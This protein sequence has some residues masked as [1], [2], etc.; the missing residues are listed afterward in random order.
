MNRTVKAGSRS[1]SV[2]APA[3]KSMAHRYLICAALSENGSEICCGT[4]SDDIEATIDCLNALGAE[5]AAE[6]G[7]IRVTPIREVPKGLCRLPC[8]ESGFG[9][10]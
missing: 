10:G 4:F 3:S 1:G 7:V 8:G 2:T 9:R 6:N 5:I